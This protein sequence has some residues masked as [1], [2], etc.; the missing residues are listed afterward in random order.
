[1]TWQK[2]VEDLQASPIQSVGSLLRG[3]AEVSPFERVSPHDFLLAILPASNRN[4]SMKLIG[5]PSSA[6][7]ETRSHDILPYLD[8]GLSAWL[9]VQ[10]VAPLPDPRKL[11]SYTS[12]VCEALQL[13]LYFS[14]PETFETLK[15][16]RARWLQ[17]LRVLNISAFR[18]PE[19]DYWQI[20]ASKQVDDA[21]QFFWQYFIAESGRTLSSRYLSLGLLALAKLPLSEEDSLRNLRIQVQALV[22]RARRRRSMGAMALDEMVE[23]LS[24]I[25][26]RNPSMSRQKYSDFFGSL[27]SPLGDNFTASVLGA[28]GL[29]NTNP[30]NFRA[31]TR[32][33]Y[34]LQPPSK[35]GYT[36][37]LLMDLGRSNSFLQAWRTISR[38]LSELEN[39][40][41]K[42]GDGYHFVRTLDRCVRAF[43]DKYPLSDPEAQ[44]Q[45]FHWVHLALRLEPDEPRRWM[46]WELVLRKA[47]QIQRAIWVLWEMTR[48]FPDNLHCRLDLAQLLISSKGYIDLNQAERL[49]HQVLH[50]DPENLHALSSLANLAIRHEKWPEAIQYAE[51][52]LCIDSNNVPCALSLA[53]AYSRR[54]EPGDLQFAVDYLKRFDIRNPFDQGIQRSLRNLESRDKFGEGQIAYFREV[55]EDISPQLVSREQDPAWQT[56]AESLGSWIDKPRLEDRAVGYSTEVAVRALPLPMTLKQAVLHDNWECDVLDQYELDTLNQFPLETKLWRYLQVMHIESSSVGERLRAKNAMQKLVDSSA[57]QSAQ[58]NHSWKSY[59]KLN[60]DELQETTG[61]TAEAGCVWLMELL[62]RHQPL[63]APLLS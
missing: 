25:V 51:R 42:S 44:S 26:A 7:I 27:I 8:S 17:W 47:N 18:D 3:S 41:H 28:L 16:D 34:T 15:K 20:L 37:E 1:M 2:W 24:G 45:V 50:L 11:S 31:S 4:V 35:P 19:F 63:P 30:D 29:S 36:D 39:Y 61:K 13:P 60:W 59:L 32:S 23:C 49:L 53:A 33:T 12:Q 40:C 54:N 5:D 22:N 46:L 57:D 6:S 48:R 9:K 55:N 56:F 14:M 52:G 62:D 21:L 10:Q 58:N 43:V 38:P